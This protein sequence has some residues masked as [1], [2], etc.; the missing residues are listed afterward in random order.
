MTTIRT[1]C[2]PRDTVVFIVPF[3][4]SAHDV[5]VLGCRD[6]AE[7]GIKVEILVAPVM[8]GSPRSGP[9][10]VSGFPVIYVANSDALDRA[11]GERAA[12]VVFFDFA[13]GLTAPTLRGAG[14]YAALRAHDALYC[15]VWSGALPPVPP[16]V[17]IASKMRSLMMRVAGAASPGRV[18]EYVGRRLVLAFSPQRLSQPAPF[19]VF[20]GHASS[21]Q[22]YLDRTAQSEASVRWINSFDYD[23]YLAYLGSRGGVAPPAEPKAVFLDEAASHHPDSRLV[24]ASGMQLADAQYSSSMRRLFDVLEARTGLRVVVAAHPRSDYGSR[25]EYFGDREIVLGQTVDLVARSSLVIAHASTAIGYAVLFDKPLMLVRTQEMSGTLH[26]AGLA[27]FANALSL[28][29]VTVGTEAQLERV[30]WDY[31]SWP[32]RAYSDYCDRYVRSPEAPA[33]KTT[34]Q[35]VIDDLVAAGV[36]PSETGLV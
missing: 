35:I 33:D 5:A 10:A 30:N 19:R 8:I 24:G 4:P 1:P 28:D 9:E 22:S 11:V 15:V 17:G 2:G 6:F 32:R 20:A 16:P 26:D 31:L 18:L 29:P 14:L 13:F 12:T 36:L 34:W 25:V 27:M 21:L 23:T 3:A 7:R